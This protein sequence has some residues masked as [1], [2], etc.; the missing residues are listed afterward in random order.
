MYIQAARTRDLPASLRFIRCANRNIHASRLV[1]A[2]IKLRKGSPGAR[3][4][5]DHG[6]GN[7]PGPGVT[8]GGRRHRAFHGR[9]TRYNGIRAD[10]V[11]LERRRSAHVLRKPAVVEGEW[12]EMT[13]G[14][15]LTT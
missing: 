1:I 15:I 6:F 12:A 8:Q 9:G 10:R 4:I 3:R 2:V 14:S 11:K 7:T 5:T 13:E